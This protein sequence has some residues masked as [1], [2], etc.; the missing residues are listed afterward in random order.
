MNNR[1]YR[2]FTGKPL[3]GFGYGL[4]Y[5]TFRYTDL[6]VPGTVSTGAPLRVSVRVTNTGKLEGEEVP[7]LYLTHE[8]L[9]DKVPLR[10]LKG[11][12]RFSL[13]AGESR[14]VTFD[15]SP[16]DLSI[17]TDDGQTRERP[18]ALSISVGGAQPGEGLPV[19]TA[20]TRI[21]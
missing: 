16:A 2:Y 3:Y 4:S 11:F 12:D 17:V 8:G 10:A 7:Q 19:V 5:T 6:Q 14:I 18:G 9:H 21:Q 15:L 20:K 13:K 1:T